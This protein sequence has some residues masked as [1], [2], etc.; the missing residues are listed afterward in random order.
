[1]TL[2]QRQQQLILE[3]CAIKDED[4]LIMLEEELTYHKNNKI[5]LAKELSPEDFNELI[6]LVNEPSEKN[7]VSLSQFRK[8]TERWRTK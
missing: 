5:D 2:L 7:T 6:S 4:I 8:A 3:I 1:M